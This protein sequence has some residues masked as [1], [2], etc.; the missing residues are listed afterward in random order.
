MKKLL[1]VV[2]L[3]SI[4]SFALANRVVNGNGTASSSAMACT[5]AK[6]NATSQRMASENVV[7]FSSCGCSQN[8][9]G[10]YTCQVD[11]SLAKN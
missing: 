6:N 3:A 9:D 2:V 4:S 5:F 1:V 11:A 10:T 7:A 8:K